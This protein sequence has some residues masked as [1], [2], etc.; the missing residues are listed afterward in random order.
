MNDRPIAFDAWEKLAEAYS[1]RVETK[2]HNALYERPATLSLLPPVEGKRVLDAGCGPGVTAQWLV[3]HGAE[4]VGFDASPKMVHLARERVGDQAKILEADL[5]NRLNFLDD[6]RLDIIISSLA[7]DYVANWDLVFREFFRVLQPAGTLVF[8]AGHPFHDFYRFKDGANYFAVEQIEEV[9]RG[10]GFEIVVPFYR[11]SLS[12]M[13]NPLIDAGFLLDKILEP[14]PLPAFE[15]KEPEDY[16][17]LMKQPGFIC[18]RAKKPR[19]SG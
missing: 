16:D 13:I 2:A 6:S 8:S 9:W 15:A 7:L 19:E 10:F 14:K 11:R 12:A 4:V 3:E 5:R 1:A 18:V 17:R